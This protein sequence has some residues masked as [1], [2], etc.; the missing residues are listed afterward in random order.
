ML[1]PTQFAAGPIAGVH[2]QVSL[3][4]CNFTTRHLFY[5]LLLL[6]CFITK[7]TGSTKQ[8]VAQ[9]NVLVTRID[10]VSCGRAACGAVSGCGRTGQVRARAPWRATGASRLLRARAVRAASWQ[11]E[12]GAKFLSLCDVVRLTAHHKHANTE[13]ALLRAAGQ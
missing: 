1:R 6:D 13:R 8:A 4:L 5:V 2:D 3:M 10:A 11:I 7:K 9:E 12:F